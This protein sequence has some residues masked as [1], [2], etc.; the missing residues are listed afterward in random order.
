[1]TTTFAAKFAGLATLALAVLPAAALTTTARAETPHAHVAPAHV[2]H[3]RI[4]DLNMTSP[5]GR[6]QFAQRTSRAADAFCGD[7]RQLSFRA[8]C[9]RAVR[10]EAHDKLATARPGQ[11][12]LARN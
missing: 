9:E 10:Q 5:D 6:A 3:V 12:E 2:A 8:A 11:L 4:A 1:M 7:Q